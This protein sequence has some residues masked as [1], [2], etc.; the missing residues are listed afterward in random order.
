MTV[1][2]IVLA[3]LAVVFVAVVLALFVH[4]REIDRCTHGVLFDRPCAQCDEA[5]YCPPCGGPCFDEG[6]EDERR[7]P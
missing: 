5:A 1:L 3:A 2:W 6:H 4:A 7:L